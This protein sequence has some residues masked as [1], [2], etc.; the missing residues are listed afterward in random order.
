M[1]IRVDTSGTTYA[2]ELAYLHT[3]NTTYCIIGFLHVP[4]R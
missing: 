1:S 2:Q 3:D 4:I